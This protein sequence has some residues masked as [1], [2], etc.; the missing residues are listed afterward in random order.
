ME[1]LFHPWHYTPFLAAL[2]F[3]LAGAG[4]AYRAMLDT[5][6]GWLFKRGVRELMANEED[7]KEQKGPAPLYTDPEF[8]EG[9]N[10]DLVQARMGVARIDHLTDPSGERL[11]K[12]LLSPGEGNPR[13]QIEVSRLDVEGA[14]SGSYAYECHE[15]VLVLLGVPEETGDEDEQQVTTRQTVPMVVSPE[16]AREPGEPVIAGIAALA[17]V[18]RQSPNPLLAVGGGELLALCN[19]LLQHMQ[20]LQAMDSETAGAI[21]KVM[22]QAKDAM[23]AAEA[24]ADEEGPPIPSFPLRKDDG[25][26]EA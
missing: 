5:W 12:A 14:P 16:K 1:H 15:A 21:M 19:T 9:K 18:L 4:V 25:P 8:D 26:A 6:G 7:D 24:A 10:A 3:I 23:D 17:A 20:V 2:P 11:V 13:I 22:G